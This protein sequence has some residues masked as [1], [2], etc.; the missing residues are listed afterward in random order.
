MSLCG[1]AKNGMSTTPSGANPR[2]SAK[3]RMSA[4]P[5]PGLGLTAGVRGGGVAH[6]QFRAAAAQSLATQQ[7]LGLIVG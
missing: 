4:T 7:G 3:N 6:I 5:I 1:E 2:W